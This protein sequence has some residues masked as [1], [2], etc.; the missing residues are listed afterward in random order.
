VS[1]G[2]NKFIGKFKMAAGDVISIRRQFMEYMYI[3]KGI[4]R[5]LVWIATGR[6]RL[7]EEQWPFILVD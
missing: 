2:Q 3:P 6:S 1:R 5:D 7:E 4:K